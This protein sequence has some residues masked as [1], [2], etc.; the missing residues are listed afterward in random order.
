MAYRTAPMTGRKNIITV[1]HPASPPDPGLHAR[2]NTNMAQASYTSAPIRDYQHF[3]HRPYDGQTLYV[4]I[5]I[6]HAVTIQVGKQAGASTR[7]A[8]G[9]I[10]MV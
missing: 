10:G 6:G 5:C 2:P 1:K 4:P 9:G 8:V 3:Q 7:A